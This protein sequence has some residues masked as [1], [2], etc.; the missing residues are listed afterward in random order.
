MSLQ[1]FL[2]KFSLNDYSDIRQ[3]LEKEED[4]IKI[5]FLFE[6]NSYIYDVIIDYLKDNKIIH[7]IDDS[8]NKN[9]IIK[10]IVLEI[11]F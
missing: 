2:N 3:V 10:L 6:S 1:K 4:Y 9:K 8:Y 7:M 11:Y 5:E